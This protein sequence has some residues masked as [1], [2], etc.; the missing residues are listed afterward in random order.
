MTSRP[1]KAAALQGGAAVLLLVLGGAW[2]I[3]ARSAQPVSGADDPSVSYEFRFPEPEHRWMQVAITFT[4]LPPAALSLRMSSASP[5]RYARHDFAKN[6]FDLQ[7]EDGAGRT[8]DPIRSGMARWDVDGHDG[9]VHVTYRIYGDRI[10]GTY[11]A[12]DETHAH[13]NMPAS[14]LW[15][16]GV[17][18]RPATVRFV[19]PPGQAWRVATQLFPSDDPLTFTA[20]NLAYLLDSPVEFS[21]FVDR[22]FTVIDPS[23]ADH[24]PRFRIALHHEGSDADLARYTD[25]IER[26][27]REMVTVFGEFPRFETGRYTFIADY[28]AGANGDAM[29]HRNSTVLS[30]SGSLDT[31]QQ[32]LLGSASH[33][34]F[35]V[36]NVERIRPRSLEPFDFER[37][38]PSDELWL[39]EGFTN[40]YGAL[41]LQRA[42]L[43]PLADTLNRFL[44]AIDTVRR[45]P[46]RQ[47]RSA[48]DMSRL[49]PFT[50]AA[51]AIDR[52]NWNN[53]FI[54]YYTW[55]EALGLGLDLLLRA[56]A[57]DGDAPA[58]T[59]DDYM[60]L[61]WERFG[62]PSDD[63]PGVVAR[64]YAQADA[65]IALA[66]LSGDATFADDFFD[67]FV[68]GHDAIDY[69]PL[70]ARAGFILAPRT[71]RGGWLGDTPLSFGQGG[72]RLVGPAPFDSPLYDAGLERDDVLVSVDDRPISSAGQL[73][74]TTGTHQ[75]GD[76]L[77]LTY[78]RRGD[79]RT[80]HVTLAADPTL[81]LVAQERRGQ[82]LTAAQRLFRANWLESRV[83]N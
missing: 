59:L 14:I 62:R 65:R 5:G 75:P 40:Y 74:E 68:E 37:V 28:L 81:T 19:S 76:Q 47:F 31:Q 7:A 71:G 82:P 53:L 4:G 30:S 35:H 78:L 58:V 21:A 83:S 73:D 38:N 56:R 25:N 12:V 69:A 77:R 64:P 42:G 27:V 20:P 3:H 9:T 63:T 1:R 41:I 48:V 10:D 66:D 54:S 23:D 13:M 49:A 34:F 79:L 80:T 33:E 15:G 16:V 18:K 26:M 44:S 46:G 39:A 55:G 29:E 8:I 24:V 50:D 11:L 51:T 43:V 45:G 60:R 2:V 6:V 52:T 32:G 61:L 70:F 57:A 67:R 17:E 72:A 22:S 36:W